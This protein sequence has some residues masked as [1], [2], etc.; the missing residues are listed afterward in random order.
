MKQS[1]HEPERF[2]LYARGHRE[3]DLEP[4]VWVPIFFNPF[5]ARRWLDKLIGND[6]YELDGD[7]ISLEDGTTV[8]ADRMSDILAADP[9]EGKLRPEDER[10]CLRFRRG[11]WAEDHTQP[12]EEA[13][14][15]QDDEGKPVKKA[16]AVKPAKPKK[17]DHFVAV[18]QWCKEWKIKPLH[19]RQAL[20]ASDIE[21]PS[22]G[23]SFDPKDKNKVKKICLA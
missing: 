14:P 19:A 8:K 11:S 5:D 13:E 2:V 4:R 9:D 16:K 10:N 18:T 21:K 6:S 1:K 15:S 23:W 7:V 3:P 12:D 17:P 20:R 22:F